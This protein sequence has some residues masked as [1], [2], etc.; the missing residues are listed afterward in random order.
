MR[1]GRA[2]RHLEIAATIW[3]VL[4][5]PPPHPSFGYQRSM[6]YSPSPVLSFFLNHASPAE[7]VSTQ[8]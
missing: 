2:R 4:M 1:G 8:R 3:R 6:S 5:Q 7:L